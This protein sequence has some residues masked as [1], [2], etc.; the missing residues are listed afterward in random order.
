MSGHNVLIHILHR[1]IVNDVSI[2]FGERAF[3]L[4][5]IG[6]Y[7]KLEILIHSFNNVVHNNNKCE[8]NCKVTVWISEIVHN[9]N[10]DQHTSTNDG[11]KVKSVKKRNLIVCVYVCIT[12]THDLVVNLFTVSMIIKTELHNRHYQ[13]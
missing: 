9:S 8:R 1:D 10:H 6:N 11:Q 3:T 2:I 7:G 13:L 12:K 5:T 4:I